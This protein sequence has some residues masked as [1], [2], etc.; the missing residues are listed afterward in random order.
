MYT[1]FFKGGGAKVQL[2]RL[3]GQ[4]ITGAGRGGGG[5]G[6]QCPLLPTQ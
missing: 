4:L 5:G 1:G 6:G 3:V 2:K